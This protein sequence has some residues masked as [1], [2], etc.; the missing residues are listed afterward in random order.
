MFSAPD[1]IGRYS[2]EFS[3]A[4]MTLL[5][6]IE[7]ITADRMIEGW[8]YNLERS[9]PCIVEL[10]F[11]ERT[12][13]SGV[14]NRFRRD[15]LRRGIGHGHVGFSAALRLPIDPGRYDVT[16]L[17]RR[18]GK[19]IDSADGD[20]KI[21]VPPPTSKVSVSVETLLGGGEGW[22]VQDL[23]GNPNCLKLDRNC[24]EMGQ[25][26]FV[27]AVYMFAVGEWPDPEIAARH[28]AALQ[29]GS[30]SPVALFTELVASFENGRML[31][32]PFDHRFPF[33]L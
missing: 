24:R 7:R 18:T 12:M 26:R 20:W 33:A 5:G 30:L 8:T 28:V 23:L 4:E 27:D 10:R 11:G 9:E 15:L 32:S 6:A 21:D 22:T 31:P 2:A 1:S 25:A 17:E 29:A 3:P 19:R 13:A 16:L 14:A